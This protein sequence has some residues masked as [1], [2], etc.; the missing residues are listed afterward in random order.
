MNS[1]ITVLYFNGRVY[2]DND[3]VIFE[4]SKKAIQIKC[5]ISFNALKKKLEIR[6]LVSGK[7]VALQI[8]DDENVETMIES[9]QQQQQMSVLELYV[10]KDVAGGSMFHA[11]NS[12]T[13]CGRNVSHDD[14]ELPRNISNLHVDE[15]DDDDDYFASNSY[16]EES[17]DEDDSDDGISDT[18][19]EVTDIVEPVSIVH[20]SQG[21]PE[22]QNPFWNDAMHYNN[23][24]W[25]HPD[26]E[27]IC[28]LDMPTTF[29]VGQELYVGIDFDSKDAVKN[30]L[31]QY[32]M[33]VHQSFKVVETKSHKYIVCCP[34]NTKESRQFYPKKTDAWKVT[35]WG[36][37]QTCLNMT[38]TQDHEKLESNL[39]A[40]C[41]IGMIREDQSIKISL[42][43][44]RINSEF[45]YKVSYR[46][47]WMAKQKAIAIEYG[48]WEE[49]Y[50]KLSSWLTHMQN[51]S[52]GSYFQ[53]LHDD[54]IVS[55]RVSREHRQ[56]H[57]VFWTFG[58]CKE[59]FKYCKPIIQVHG[60]HLYGKYR[61]TLLMAT[62]QDG[63]GGV[64]PLAFAVVEGET[65]TA[66]SW[67][68]AHLRE[69]VTDKN[70]ICLI[71]DRRASIKSVFANEALG[72]QPP[73]AYTPCKH[74]FD[75][76]LEKFRQLSPAIAR[77]ID[78][79][80]KEKWSMA[81]DTSRRR[82]GHMTTNLS[83]CVNKVLKDCRSIPITALVKST[84]SRCRKYFVD[85]EQACSH[86]VRVYDIHSTR[87][88]VEETFN[89]ITQRGGQKWAV[90]LNGHYCQCGRYFALHYP[91]SHII[92]ACAAIPPSDEAWTL[93]PD[94][95]T[96]RAKG[97][98][99]STRIRNEMDWIEPSDHRQKCSRCGA[100]GHNRRRCPMQSDRGSN[101]FN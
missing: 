6:F 32:V 12:V 62:S 48:D 61:G 65:L 14:S 58:Q 19:D 96:I 60:T 98:P 46:K 40:T 21:V 85:R 5:G 45:S 88:E 47:A 100:E 4:G 17:F 30:A 29:N 56:F 67:V 81:Y 44:E 50:A 59:A 84:Y 26:E 77:W 2:E 28:G 23:I 78:R 95:T 97:R 80:S 89:P 71:S 54:F 3:G 49:S 68:L 1:I 11:A 8:C 57:R 94:P 69:H 38:M 51:H 13:S 64:L 33:K 87:F 37:P 31:K 70:G 22:I 9:F 73:N 63:N 16:V 35:Q 83:E 99:K 74:V 92:A 24:N 27:D 93:I 76:N 72:W 55:N 41:V 18:D 90:N 86:I 36:G 82:Y 42:I 66:W 34:N 53:I 101:S 10:E 43:Q 79:I 39:I 15:D 25:S 75:Q 91:C 52:P 20:P 7:Y